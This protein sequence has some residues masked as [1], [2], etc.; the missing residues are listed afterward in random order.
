M[1]TRSWQQTF[2]GW[3]AAS[4]PA[5]SLQ[6][7]L[8]Y[9]QQGLWIPVA[10]RMTGWGSRITRCGENNGG[11]SKD[12]MLGPPGPFH[13]P[14]VISAGAGI[15]S[16]DYAPKRS[17]Q[18]IFGGRTAG[19]HP[20]LSLQHNLHYTQQGLWIPVATR[21]TG[22]GSRIP[23]A[24]RIT[25]DNRKTILGPCLFLRAGLLWGILGSNRGSR[26]AKPTVT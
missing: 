12:H 16:L 11:Q 19:S 3:T 17:W 20:A 21:M 25:G 10:T 23:A 6:H 2:G 18:Q 1:P 22:W 14:L 26:T 9:T 24:T 4:H 7:N 8:H 13:S 15:Q 5:L